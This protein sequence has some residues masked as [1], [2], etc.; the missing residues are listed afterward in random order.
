M[1]EEK[2]RRVHQQA[3]LALQEAA[4]AYVP[5]LSQSERTQAVP[6]D[7]G[8]G[9]NDYNRAGVPKLSS[10][11]YISGDI[12]SHLSELINLVVILAKQTRI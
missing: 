7:F 1:D 4:E 8:Y 10:E 2:L 3:V 5:G 9:T 6:D 12:Y 11:S